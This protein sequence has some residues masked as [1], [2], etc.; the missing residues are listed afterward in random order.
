[1]SDLARGG[2]CGDRSHDWVV[3]H[4]RHNHSAFNGYHWTGSD[5]SQV[6]CLTC[7]RGWRTKA[8]YVSTLPYEQACR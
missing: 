8:D 5:Y 4:L 3:D 7:N 6:R 2:A 1:M